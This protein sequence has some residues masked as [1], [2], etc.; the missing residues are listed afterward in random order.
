MIDLGEEIAADA[1]DVKGDLV[2][3]SKSL[4]ILYGKRFALKVSIS[5][6]FLVII[7]SSLPF[8]LSWFQ[9]IYLLPVII[10]D[11]SI[12]L[13]ALKLFNSTEQEGRRYIRH[14]YFGS[15]FGLIIFL[16]MKMVIE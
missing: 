5:I 16:I 12:A 8:F 1:M 2:I 13:P 9:P 11:A 4:A 10:M 7:I 6:F 3:K 15:T 14:I